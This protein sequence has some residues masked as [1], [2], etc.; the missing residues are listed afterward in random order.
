[1]I[2]NLFIDLK[3]QQVMKIQITNDK[4]IYDLCALAHRLDNLKTAVK[5][6]KFLLDHKEYYERTK[7]PCVAEEH[8]LKDLETMKST[9]ETEVNIVNASLLSLGMETITIEYV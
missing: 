9:V 4:Q 8:Y 7:R 2:N 5:N 3:T 6:Y 1:M